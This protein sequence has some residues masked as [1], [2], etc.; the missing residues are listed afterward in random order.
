M[1]K[2]RYNKMQSE[3]YEL[4]T[5]H[6]LKNSLA[7]KKGVALFKNGQCEKSCEIRKR[8]GQEMA[9]MVLVDG[10]NFNNNNS[11]EFSLGISTKFP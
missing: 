2:N 3:S 10:K 1:Q 8:G 7:V 5:Y 11:G 4:L 6:P 9:V